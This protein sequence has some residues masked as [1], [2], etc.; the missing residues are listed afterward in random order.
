MLYRSYKSCSNKAIVC[1][2]LSIYNLDKHP[3]NQLQRTKF[4]FYF[5]LDSDFGFDFDFH[6]DFGVGI[7]TSST[8]A[9][10]ADS[11]VSEYAINMAWHDL[12]SV[13]SHFS[14]RSA[15]ASFRA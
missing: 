4:D 5:G 15:T 10:A 3:Q 8:H 12:A 6:V 1:D 13:A 14:L 11:V 9:D 7:D 2:W